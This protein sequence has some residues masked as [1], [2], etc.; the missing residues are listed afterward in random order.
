MRKGTKRRKLTKEQ[1]AVVAGI[2]AL[3]E[4]RQPLNISAVRR[5]HPDLLLKTYRVKPFWGWKQAIEAAGLDYRKIKVSIP[6]TIVCKVCGAKRM[7]L[8]QH[9]RFHHGLSPAQYQDRYGTR[10]MSSDA[11]KTKRIDRKAARMVIPHWEPHWSPEYV[12]DRLYQFHRMGIPLHPSNIERQEKR[13]YHW[14]RHFFKTYDTA[15]SA[16]G[17]DP[18]EVRRARPKKKWTKRPLIKAVCR[19]KARG[20]D[21]N[22]KAMHRRD[23]SIVWIAP[24]LFGSYDKMLKAA[25]LDPR[26]ERKQPKAKVPYKT[27]DDVIAGICRRK[28]KGLGLNQKRGWLIFSS[29]PNMLWF[30]GVEGLDS[31]RPCGHRLLDKAVEKFAA[32]RGKS[33]VEAEGKFIQVCL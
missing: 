21:V 10:V 26:K 3:H 2:A 12:L 8:D 13:L 15:L 9:V 22:F 17:F 28:L 33:S 5:N 4:K 27:K 25:G 32:M 23:A 18:S 20:Q 30:L 1:H 11:L 31:R 16:L 14:T 6:R 19:M 24:K 7:R 29:T